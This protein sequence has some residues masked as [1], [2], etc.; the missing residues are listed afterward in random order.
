MK[1]KLH[2][3]F[4]FF[5]LLMIN[6]SFIRAQ[7]RG[8]K[9]NPKEIKILIDSLS[10]AL[11]AQYIYA[12]KA[13]I[14]VSSIAKKYKSGVYNN[15]K[16]RM[17]LAMELS[18]DLQEAWPDKHLRLNYNPKFAKKLE[19]PKTADE[20]KKD[21]EMK[22]KFALENNFAF[23]KT[24]ILPGNIGYVR[25]DGFFEFIE[26]ARPTMNSAFQFVSNCKAV[27]IDM[28]YNGGGSPDMVAA[29]QN[30][31]FSEKVHL[32]DIIYRSR[33]TVVRYSDPGKTTFKLN[34]PVY[35]LTSNRT[36]SGAEDFTYGM[37]QTNRATIVGDTTGGGAHPT[38]PVSVGQGFVAGI[39]LGC[40]PKGKDWEGTGI[41]PTIPIPS[42]Q[43]LVTAQRQAFT[44]LLL[45]AK[46]DME[47]G[48]I[49]WELN[50]L[51]AVETLDHVGPLALKNYAGIYVGGLDF[52]LSD[53]KLVCK[54]PEAGGGVVELKF[55]S[56]DLFLMDEYVQVKF[57]KDATGNYSKIKLF[58]RNGMITEK[59]KTL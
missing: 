39:P 7:D 12:D 41:Y 49:T 54:N 21:Q 22:L 4:A 47:K 25:W 44:D 2:P 17:E 45:K 50:N 5:F 40:A 56:E 10:K 51:K 3:V 37:Q 11:R 52:Y 48:A 16:D 46:D 9:M 31:F 32:N 28:R 38:G 20:E 58:W 35:I 23:K 6:P 42:E 1:I 18:Q 24:E 15:A 14:M 27:I 13:E 53:Q 55:I 59:Q 26:E 43:A 57:E 36:F 34:M 30:Y 29:T 8:P 19:T 33:D